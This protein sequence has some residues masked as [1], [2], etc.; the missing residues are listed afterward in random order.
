M[1]SAPLRNATVKQIGLVVHHLEDAVQAWSQLLG[2]APPDI[3]IT[4]PVHLAHTE[5]QRQ[6][7][8]ARA[9]L[10][11]FQLGQVEMEWIEPM[12]EPSTWH[13]QLAAHGPSLHH[14]A[15]EVEGMA[16]QLLALAEHGLPVLQ[17]GEY[18]G[19]RYAYLDGQG[20]FGAIVELLEND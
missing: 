4:D 16:D 19:G 18:Q 3:I 17:R 20:R 11:F 10:A 2:V 8:P 1:T 14:I 13:D 12:G 5:Y 6:P 15:F 7:S 9:R